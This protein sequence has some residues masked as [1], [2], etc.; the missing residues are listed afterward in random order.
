MRIRAYA[1]DQ[2][3]PSMILVQASGGVAAL[4]VFKKSTAVLGGFA[5]QHLK[6]NKMTIKFKAKNDKANMA[7]AK[8]LGAVD[9]RL[10]LDAIDALGVICDSLAQHHRPSFKI[11][12][13]AKITDALVDAGVIGRVDMRSNFFVKPEFIDR[14]ASWETV[15][16]DTDERNNIV[17]KS[18]TT[19]RTRASMMTLRYEDVASLGAYKCYFSQIV[20][21]ANVVGA[22][23]A[24]AA[25]TVRFLS[26]DHKEAT[27]E[28]VEAFMVK[29]REECALAQVFMAEIAEGGLVITNC[30]QFLQTLNIAGI[31]FWNNHLVR[32]A[33]LTRGDYNREETS[34]GC[35]GQHGS[36]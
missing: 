4:L 16:A 28:R 17:S 13:Q 8:A 3:R 27:P 9:Q 6:V 23:D 30:Q 31:R 19:Y 32:F 21:L 36:L 20:D 2:Q 5:T 25:P 29:L 34:Y 15:A 10:R 12:G 18:N 1:V 33:L 22:F 35:Y 14:E 26:C 7:A 11:V 24:G